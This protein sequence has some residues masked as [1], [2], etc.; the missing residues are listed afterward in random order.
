MAASNLDGSIQADG[1][2]RI[3]GQVQKGKFMYPQTHPA[4]FDQPMINREPLG[5]FIL[6]QTLST[7][8]IVAVVEEM[9]IAEHNFQPSMFYN[10]SFILIVEPVQQKH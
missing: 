4:F 6:E 2:L 9:P 3:D 5:P 8:S 10:R 7:N 1:Q